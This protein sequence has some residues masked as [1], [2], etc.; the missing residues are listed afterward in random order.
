MINN[1]ALLAVLGI[2]TIGITTKSDQ[3]EWLEA[4]TNQFTP[5]EHDHPNQPGVESSED[6]EEFNRQPAFEVILG[7]ESNP[8]QSSSQSTP[9]ITFKNCFNISQFNSCQFCYNTLQRGPKGCYGAIPADFHCIMTNYASACKRCEPGYGLVYTPFKGHSCQPT[10]L[11]DNC[12]IAYGAPNFDFYVCSTCK[13]GYYVDE[14]LTGCIKAEDT[15]MRVE[16]CLWGGWV[17]NGRRLCRRCQSGYVLNQNRTA[18]LAQERGVNDKCLIY[19]F[20]NKVCTSCD[21]YNGFSAQLNR[22]CQ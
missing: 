2:L 7:Q 8:S 3:S 4:E 15:D 22:T 14:T 5:K 10:K 12:Q 16:N 19:D 6:S 17:S 21:V 18:C 11:D 20:E 13:A 1:L 9:N